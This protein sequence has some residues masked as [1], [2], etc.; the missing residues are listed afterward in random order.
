[1]ML[2]CQSCLYKAFTEQK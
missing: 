2:F 1:M